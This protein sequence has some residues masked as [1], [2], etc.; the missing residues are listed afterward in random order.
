MSLSLLSGQALL[1]HFLFNIV[2]IVL[3]MI[4]AFFDSFGVRQLGFFLEE[5]LLGGCPVAREGSV[6]FVWCLLVPRAGATEAE[7]WLA[8]PAR[9]GLTQPA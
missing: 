1:C 5:G 4:R 6:E 3:L 2:F 8:G 9:A 7:D